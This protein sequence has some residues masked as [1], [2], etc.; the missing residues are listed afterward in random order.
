MSKHVLI[1][2]CGCENYGR[3]GSLNH[4]LSNIA[5][6]ELQKLGY[7]T[8]ITL[9]DSEWE[10]E[11]EAEKFKRA[12]FVIVQT[13]GWWMSTPWQFKRYLDLVWMQ[14]GI[15]HGD[16]RHHETPT[17]GYGTGGILNDK[18]YMLSSTWNAPIQAFTEKDQFFKGKGIDGVFFWLHKAFAFIGMKPM[19]SFICNDVLKNPKI[20]E[21]VKRWKEHIKKNFG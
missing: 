16:G 10:P 18:K 2:D 14:P 5:D 21:D 4:Y 17:K 20:D 12:D 13:P 11:A 1:I 3:G 19:E 9:V 7:T 15:A 8:E 6:E